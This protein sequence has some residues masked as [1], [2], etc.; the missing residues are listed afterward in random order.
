VEGKSTLM[1]GSALRQREGGFHGY[2]RYAKNGPDAENASGSDAFEPHSGLASDLF[3][4]PEV[5]H[6]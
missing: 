2:G 1:R 6:P 4:S 5:D 3:N